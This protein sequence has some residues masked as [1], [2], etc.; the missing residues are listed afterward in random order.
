[1]RPI[2]L[3][4]FA[5][6]SGDSIASWEFDPIL[7]PAHRKCQGLG[8]LCKHGMVEA[9]IFPLSPS[10]SRFDCQAH[11]RGHR[12][13]VFVDKVKEGSSHQTPMLA[14]SEKSMKVG[15]KLQDDSTAMGVGAN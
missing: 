2:P 12:L 4:E 15:V 10:I 14:G 7:A 13:P 9:L 6:Q 1:M 11:L 8:H 3:L 5:R